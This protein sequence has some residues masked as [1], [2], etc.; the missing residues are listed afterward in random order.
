MKSSIK[1]SRGGHSISFRGAAAR[2][3]FEGITGTKLPA[4][5]APMVMDPNR[6]TVGEKVRYVNHV[7]GEEI[8]LLVVTA[9]KGDFV[10][11]DRL[12]SRSDKPFKFHR[13]GRATWSSN[14]SIKHE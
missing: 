10:M 5:E 14:L 2:A 8:G 11:A 13:D 6:F 3:A 12:L 1:V 4:A 9:L 7:T